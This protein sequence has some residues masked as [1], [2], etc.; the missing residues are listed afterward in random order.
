MADFR[1]GAA[2]AGRGRRL[3]DSVELDEGAAGLHVRV[4]WRF[5]HREDGGEA[6]FA[7]RH[8]LAPLVSRFPTE[9]LREARPDG[10]P[11]FPIVPVGRQGGAVDAKAVE[12]RFV[13]LRLV[14]S[15]RYPLAV[16]G[17]V[18]I[19]PRRARIEP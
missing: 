19:V 7:S 9:L 3:H 17:L 14:A 2:E 4:L 16:R 1:L 6:D 18:D 12:Q 8:D 15:H 13:E 11:A 10:G 5:G